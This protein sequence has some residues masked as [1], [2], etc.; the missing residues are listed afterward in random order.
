MTDATMTTAV[1]VGA[2]AGA[3][4]EA[5]GRRAVREVLVTRLD[6]AGM[7]RRKGVTEAEHR[8]WVGRLVDRLAYMSRANLAVLADHLLVLGEGKLRAEWPREVT[9]LG[10]AEGLQARPIED[11]PIVQSWL[12]SVEG[13]VAVAGGFEVELLRFLRKARRGHV[14]VVIL[15]LGQH[16]RRV[17]SDPTLECDRDINETACYGFPP[18]SSKIATARVQPAEPRCTFTG[19]QEMV[20]PLG[21]SLSRLESFSMWQ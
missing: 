6:G 2:V 1:P 5:E 8:E 14:M 4:V 18:Y 17:G 3:E 21:G 7:M 11:A 20:K 13:P 16:M 19:R 9:I 10:W 15:N 12:R